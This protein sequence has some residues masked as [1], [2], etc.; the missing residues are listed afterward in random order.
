[1]VKYK[2]DARRPWLEQSLIHALEKYPI[3]IMSEALCH[4]SLLRRVNDGLTEEALRQ[5]LTNQVTFAI[6][7]SRWAIEA[8]AEGVYDDEVMR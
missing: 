6:E 7:H 3:N 2:L 5:E 4:Y 1:M 8:R